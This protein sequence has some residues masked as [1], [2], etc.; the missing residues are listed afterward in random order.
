MRDDPGWIYLIHFDQPIGNDGNH[1]RNKAQHYWGHA[2]PG[3]LMSQLE[4][5]RTEEKWP[6]GSAAAVL[7]HLRRQGIDWHVADL[8]PGSYAD[9]QR[10]KRRGHAASHCPT[11]IAERNHPPEMEAG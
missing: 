11:C 1:G 10:V 2:A 9:E 4:A 3:R 6:N 5:E 8:Q 7:A